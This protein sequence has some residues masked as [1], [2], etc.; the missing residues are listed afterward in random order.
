MMAVFRVRSRWRRALGRLGTAE[1]DQ[2]EAPGDQGDAFT[3]ALARIVELVGKRVC[4][5]A[6]TEVDGTFVSLIG[7]LECSV[8]VPGLEARGAQIAFLVGN[9]ESSTGSPQASPC[10]SAT[11]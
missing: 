4:V 5:E 3:L 2:P 11:S 9:G 1:R 6:S 10:A 7:T 8:E